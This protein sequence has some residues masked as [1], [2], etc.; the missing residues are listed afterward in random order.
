MYQ[1]PFENVV[2]FAQ[3]GSSH[4]AGLIAVGERPLDQLAALA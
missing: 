3:L 4:A 1:Q 2:V